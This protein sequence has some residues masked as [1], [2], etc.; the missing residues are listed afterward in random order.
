MTHCLHFLIIPPNC[1]CCSR[2]Q[3]GDESELARSYGQQHNLETCNLVEAGISKGTC[4]C[5]L[6]PFRILS[7][8]CHNMLPSLTSYRD[9]RPKR[10]RL[11]KLRLS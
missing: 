5:F 2:V 8:V 11:L 1:R 9:V 6:F 7:W 3:V 4:M 10:A